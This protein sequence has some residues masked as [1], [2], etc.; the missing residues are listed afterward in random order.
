M[1]VGCAVGTWYVYIH[2]LYI[3]IE[4]YIH[5]CCHTSSEW[6]YQWCKQPPETVCMY[7][8][9][10]CVHT[11]DVLGGVWE[12]CGGKGVLNWT[13]CNMHW[14]GHSF[15]LVS[16]TSHISWWRE[17]Y[18]PCGCLHDCNEVLEVCEGSVGVWGLCEGSVRGLWGKGWRC[19]RGVRG[20]WWCVKGIILPLLSGQPVITCHATLDCR[21][22]DCMYIYLLYHT[23]VHVHVHLSP[24]HTHVHVSPIHTHVHVYLPWNEDT[25]I[26]MWPECV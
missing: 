8:C 13:M 11:Q 14:L 23:H 21:H 19:V 15:W 12:A 2:Q 6:E 10:S 4:S 5:V 18:I 7:C 22:V 25:S 9:H 16:D 17:D 24:I 20:V 26:K 1:C 3:N